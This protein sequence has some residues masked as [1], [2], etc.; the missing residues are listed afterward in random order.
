MA[1]AV[2]EVLGFSELV[3]DPEGGNKATAWRII[4]VMS[5]EGLD[6]SAPSCVPQG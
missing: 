4:G 5:K 1:A 2:A 6:V 3:S